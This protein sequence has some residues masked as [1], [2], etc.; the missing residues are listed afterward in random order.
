MI[1]IKQIRAPRVL[2]E[3]KQSD[4][5]KASK[6]SLPT[7]NNIERGIGSPKA[8]TLDLIRNSLESNGIEF[9]DEIGVQLKGE[10][11]NF[12]ML[13]GIE[14]LKK[15]LDDVYET[16]KPNKGEVLISGLDERFFKEKLGDGLEQHIKRLAVADIKERLLIRKGDDF[17]VAPKTA[18]RHI[19]EELF[20]QMPYYVYAN[21]CAFVL[22][23][24]PLKILLIE[25]AT[26]VES[27]K[28]QF[29][30]NWQNAAKA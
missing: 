3:W 23:G 11:L 4:L 15:L 18:Y 13:E 12:Q 6:L 22:W 24:P 7:I 16:L 8:E 25:N 10:I 14:G 2:L 17:L 1:S 26:L 27:F 5:A 28:K 21:K 30:R 9:I 29:E 19:P 20:S